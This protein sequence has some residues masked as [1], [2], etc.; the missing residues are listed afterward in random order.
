MF[1]CFVLWPEPTRCEGA[2]S[3]Q[4]F[5]LH[6][7]IFGHCSF[8][9]FFLFPHLFSLFF[10]FL[11]PPGPL[12]SFLRY[13]S[14]PKP[15]LGPLVGTQALLSIPFFAGEGRRVFCR[16][17]VTF[18]PF[19]PWLP[20]PLSRSSRFSPPLA[21]RPCSSS[22]GW[23]RRAGRAARP[24]PRVFLALFRFPLNSREEESVAEKLLPLC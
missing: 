13:P 8:F 23:A 9:F 7:K 21:F 18:C 19:A 22:D 1:V 2:T 3:L 5:L 6:K 4:K 17:W 20:S 12:L 24:P 14:P 15:P 10:F 16:S 11:Q